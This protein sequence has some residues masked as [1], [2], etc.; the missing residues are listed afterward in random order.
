MESA[1]TLAI[2]PAYNEEGSVVQTVSQLKTCLPEVDY[3][4]INDGST[5]NTRKLCVENELSFIDLPV[6]V[7]LSVGF[8]TG[9]KYANNHGYDCAFQY[10]ADGQHVPDY[11]EPM[12]QEMFASGSDIVIGS[13][14]ITEK[15]RATPRMIGSYL[16]A[17]LIQ[18]T[19]GKKLS[20]PTSGLRLYN[21][22]MIERFATEHDFGPEPDT[23]AYL[24]RKGAKV[25]E[26]QANMRDRETGESYLTA[27]ASI[28][29]MMR[30]LVSIMFVQWFR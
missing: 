28:K 18:V 1:K 17:F 13:R 20:D 9:M 21:R 4:V 14:F 10:D 11:I 22:R 5:D 6:N 27:S 19:T 8:Q 15:K 16:I 30:T 12:I 29:Y 23:I 7:G 25:S 2:I 24:I 3:I 26:V